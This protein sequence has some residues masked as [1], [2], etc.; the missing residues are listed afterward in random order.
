MHASIT[1]QMLKAGNNNNHYLIFMVIICEQVIRV[2]LLWVNNHYSSDFELH[3]SPA[4][5]HFLDAFSARLHAHGK[6]GELELLD[7]ARSTWTR[8]RLLPPLA[9]AGGAEGGGR[10]GF[11]FL[12]RPGGGQGGGPLYVHQV[13]ARTQAE[14]VGLR[15]GDQV[16]TIRGLSTVIIIIC[17]L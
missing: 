7:L 9:R 13:G 12:A 17:F 14:T 3:P 8:P 6:L 1:A 4:M 15:R 10:W 5:L 2:V 11:G 16:G